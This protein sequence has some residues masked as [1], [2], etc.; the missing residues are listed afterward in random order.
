M[1]ASP[2][3]G[4][5]TSAF[6]GKSLAQNR[7]PAAAMKTPASNHLH[8]LS[9]SSQP[10]STPLGAAAIHDELLNLNSPAAALINSI[11]QN[12]LTPVPIGQDGLG[13]PP[14]SRLSTRDGSRDPESERIHRLQQAINQLKS[15]IVGR[16]VTR[17]G[18]KRVAQLHGFEALVD[19]EEGIAVVAG[20]IV[21]I[22]IIF[23]T[24]VKDKVRD[25]SFKLNFDD[26]EHVQI[27]GAEVLAAQ[28]GAENG[29]QDTSRVNLS[30]FAKNIEYLAQL[31]RLTIKPN[32]FQLVNNLSACLHD[33]WKEE[34]KKM[35]WR[36]ELHHLRKG[37]MGKPSMDRSPSMG[38]S[39]AYWQ[40]D[41]H[42][43]LDNKQE[44]S[45]Q[46]QQW[47]ADLSCESGPPNVM[48]SKDW[49]KA[50]ILTEGRPG[51]N[52]L[53]AKD[54]IYHPDWRDTS[55]GLAIKTDQ[56]KEDT[57][58]DVDQKTADLPQPLNV[59]FTCDIT[60]EVLVPVCVLTKLTSEVRMLEV[61]PRK[62]ITYQQVLQRKRN[63]VLTPRPADSVIEDRWRRK[64]PCIGTDDQ[65]TWQTQSYKIYS[66]SPDTELWCYPITS[67][68]FNHPRQL[69]DLLP[70]LRMHIVVWSLL[71]TV[72]TNTPHSAD[73]PKIIEKG[74]VFR[75][76]NRPIADSNN[77]ELVRNIDISLDFTSNTSRT[78]MEIMTSVRTVKAGKVKST[79]LHVVVQIGLN[80]VVDAT[81]ID[82]V[83]EKENDLTVLMTR[84]AEMLTATEDVGIVMQWLITRG[85]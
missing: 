37:A 41:S 71:E 67:L 36:D 14:Q 16:G 80:G 32:A 72:V 51:Q 35:H 33:V 79:F 25:V 65:V 20:Q 81:S 54:H 1:L 74:K 17:D 48:A 13:V 85:A 28:I 30:E 63:A 49:L 78:T 50:D 40:K 3:P 57:A 58:M 19:E 76:S 7:S 68:K 11:A 52:V 47:R 62:A 82:G 55:A 56:T 21:E 75:R 34:K 44:L 61:D 15:A 6:G 43:Q 46:G 38:L 2:R 53:D 60:P 12:N 84:V 4:T 45:N 77:S 64:L 22:E 39:V 70:I 42:Q 18:I 26:E 59:H 66:S 9:I 5:G 8:G 10:S 73:P 83:P 23:D 31:D 29:Q 69:A 24:V 27:S